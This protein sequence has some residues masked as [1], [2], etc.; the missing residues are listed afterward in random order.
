MKMQLI[1]LFIE[2]KKQYETE[3]STVTHVISNLCIYSK[4][5]NEYLFFTHFFSSFICFIKDIY[6]Y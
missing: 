1:N 4:L 2:N 3:N 6:F 5:V